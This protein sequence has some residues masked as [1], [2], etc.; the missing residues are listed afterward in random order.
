V[1]H[2]LYVYPCAELYIL[3]PFLFAYAISGTGNHQLAAHAYQF[4]V[5]I[6]TIINLGTVE[7]VE[8]AGTGGSLFVLDLAAG[9]TLF[10]GTPY[11]F[12]ITASVGPNDPAVTGNNIGLGSITLNGSV[13]PEPGSFALVAGGM[14]VLVRVL[15][16]ARS[17]C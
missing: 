15:R 7:V 14:C 8:P 12:N 4:T 3:R 9:T 17:G 6:N 16:R 5:N 10:A 13:V 2:Q 1:E 11:T